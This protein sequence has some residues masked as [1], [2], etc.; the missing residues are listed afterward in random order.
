MIKLGQ[1]KIGGVLDT[2]QVNEQGT[3]HYIIVIPR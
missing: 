1:L 3:A 2:C